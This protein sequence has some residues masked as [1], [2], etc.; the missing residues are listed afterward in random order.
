M[1]IKAEKGVISLIAVLSIGMFALGT[2]L[3][4]ARGVLQQLVVNRSNV[5]TYQ[6]FYAAESGAEEGAYQFV[7]APD[8]PPYTGG[9]LAT[10]INDT[11]AEI[12][13]TSLPFSAAIINGG[14]SKDDNSRNVFYYA[15]KHP[16]A[17]AFSYGIYTPYKIELSGHVTVNNGNVF[18]GEEVCCGGFKADGSCDKPYPENN[19]SNVSTGNVEKNQDTTSPSID[20]Q[21][22]KDAAIANSSYFEK[23][24]DVPNKYFKDSKTGVIFINDSFSISESGAQVDG[25]LWINGDLDLSGGTFS[26]TDNYFAIIVTGNLKIS[27]NAT[28]NGVVYVNGDTEIGSGNVTINGSLICAG[29]ASLIN[30]GGT[31]TVNYDSDLANVWDDFAGLTLNAAPEI[32]Q[33][34]EK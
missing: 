11:S 16:E 14:A 13:V 30:A 15:L 8:D 29:A 17:P 21:P 9:T 18:A 3:I 32:D 7:H 19:C 23:K 24:T 28:I 33:W 20:S 27:G 12:T 1:K 31:L 5:S 6:A 26:A 4:V 25:A 34:G 22:Y 2:S 10:L